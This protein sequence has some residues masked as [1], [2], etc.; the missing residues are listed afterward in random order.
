[1]LNKNTFAPT[2]SSEPTFAPTPCTSNESDVI[3]VQVYTDE[4]PE[5]TYWQLEIEGQLVE[6]V[7]LGEY[8][9]KNFLY[10][11]YICA[12]P[13]ISTNNICV[14]F[15]IFD[16]YGDGS[17]C[18]NGNGYYQ[19]FRVLDDE[20]IMILF[21]DEGEFTYSQIEMYGKCAFGETILQYDDDCFYGRSTNY[22]TNNLYKVLKKNYLF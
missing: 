8:T 19:V 1:M 15:Y 5:E 18:S 7:Q 21:Q 16:D 22:S 10:T 17:C 6:E 3:V 13:T 2:T 4:F 12:P 11:H 9:E 20:D 14:M